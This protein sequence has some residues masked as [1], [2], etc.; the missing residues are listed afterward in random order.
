MT[1]PR[2]R[3][4]VHWVP[5]VDGGRTRL[6]SS[7]RLVH[8]AHFLE[9]GPTWPTR[10]SW[11]VALRFDRPPIEEPTPTSAEVS[12]WMENAPHDRLQ[13]GRRFDLYEGLGKIAV[14]EIVEPIA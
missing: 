6:P 7:Q 4:L 5:V 13:P 11:S 14:V 10:E 1:I 3:G 9:D 2:Y 12:F 8:P